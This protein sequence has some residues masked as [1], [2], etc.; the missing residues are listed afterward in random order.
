[1]RESVWFVRVVGVEEKSRGKGIVTTTKFTKSRFHALCAC[2][3]F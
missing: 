1:M 2:Y 3:L